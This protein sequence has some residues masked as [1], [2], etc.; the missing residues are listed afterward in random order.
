METSS[1]QQ[2]LEPHD[3]ITIT[4]GN[5]IYTVEHVYDGRR[6][7]PEIMGDFLEQKMR[8]FDD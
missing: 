3:S 4:I 1:A 7:L 5:T 6:S 8:N 2:R